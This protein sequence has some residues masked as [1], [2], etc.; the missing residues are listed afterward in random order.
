MGQLSWLINY[1]LQR[2]LI[3]CWQIKKMLKWQNYRQ[4][5]DLSGCTDSSSISLRWKGIY[6][7]QYLYLINPFIRWQL[8]SLWTHFIKSLLK[9]FDPARNILGKVFKILSFHWKSL[10]TPCHFTDTCYQCMVPA[11]KVTGFWKGF[12]FCQPS[13]PQGI[14]QLSQWV[15]WFPEK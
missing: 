9:L 3:L 7:T 15:K 8:T 13:L 12:I 11:D 14:G 10:S 2:R 6:L 1:S 5:Q 4:W